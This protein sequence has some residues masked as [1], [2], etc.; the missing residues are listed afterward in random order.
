MSLHHQSNIFGL[1]LCL[2]I[3]HMMIS[4]NRILRI[5]LFDFSMHEKPHR[6]I[7]TC[8]SFCRVSHQNVLSDTESRIQSV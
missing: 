4:L 3:L 8:E 5:L 2:L 1:L 7:L 6:N